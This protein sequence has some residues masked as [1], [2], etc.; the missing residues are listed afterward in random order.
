MFG[1]EFSALALANPLCLSSGTAV[2]TTSAAVV[3]QSPQLYNQ[4]S[5][6]PSSPTEEAQPS[7]STSTQ[8]PAASPTGVVPGTKYAVP[9]TSTYQYDESSG[10][11]Y[12]PTTGLYYDPNSQVHTLFSSPV[13]LEIS[14]FHLIHL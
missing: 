13:S 1:L 6:P 3:S 8:A 2:T 10:Y 9:D 11:Y 5:N 4:T 7:T 14:L 12:D